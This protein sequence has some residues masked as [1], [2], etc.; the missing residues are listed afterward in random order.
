MQKFSAATVILDP[1]EAIV[2]FGSGAHGAAATRR[3]SGPKGRNKASKGTKAHLVRE[4]TRQAGVLKTPERR[5]LARTIKA[6]LQGM[7]NKQAAGHLASLRQGRGAST[8]YN[9]GLTK[10][11]RAT[12]VIVPKGKKAKKR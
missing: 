10:G 8:N 4:S 2:S 1:D 12:R 11:R 6:N 5:K 3:G 7:T 9:A